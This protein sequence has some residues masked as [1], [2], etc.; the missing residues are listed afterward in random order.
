MYIN[1]LLVYLKCII[2][3]LSRAIIFPF[4]NK[5]DIKC[6][7]TRYRHSIQT[8]VCY[9]SYV[10]YIWLDHLANLHYLI[11][12]LY[13]LNMLLFQIVAIFF[14]LCLRI[15]IRHYKCYDVSSAYI[16][17]YR[18]YIIIC[19]LMIRFQTTST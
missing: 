10:C 5:R 6:I 11:Y 1:W 19:L 14:K 17:Q 2:L 13:S 8:N 16:I 15:I 3:I 4:Q 12:S 18:Y 7:I 9:T